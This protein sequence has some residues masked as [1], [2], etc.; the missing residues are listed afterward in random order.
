MQE[1]SQILFHDSDISFSISVL[2]VMKILDLSSRH[3]WNL[4]THYLVG[5]FQVYHYHFKK[6]LRYK[7]TISS[8]NMTDSGSYIKVPNDEEEERMRK[9]AEESQR[10]RDEAR[11]KR[12]MEEAMKKAAESS[13]QRRKGGGNV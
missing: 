8:S 4:L 2:Q 10:K 1:H 3:S 12:E 9:A 7:V 11:K 5:P 6:S 13:Q